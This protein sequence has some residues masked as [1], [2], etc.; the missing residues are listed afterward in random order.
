MKTASITMLCIF[1]RISTTVVGYLYFGVTFELGAPFFVHESQDTGGWIGPLSVVMAK[2]FTETNSTRTVSDAIHSSNRVVVDRY[3]TRYLQTPSSPYI[4]FNPNCTLLSYD[5]FDNY[6]GSRAVI[7][8]A[9]VQSTANNG[10]SVYDPFLK[11]CDNGDLKPIL[12][13]AQFEFVVDK[14]TG[15]ESIDIDLDYKM[16]TIPDPTWNR[17]MPALKRK[18]LPVSGPYCYGEF[19]IVCQICSNIMVKYCDCYNISC[20]QYGRHI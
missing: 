11:T 20:C 12:P 13:L 10:S 6:F 18:G 19:V 4:R 7:N 8:T 16:L 17:W 3:E 15:K 9:K 14:E 1:G 5:D 2:N